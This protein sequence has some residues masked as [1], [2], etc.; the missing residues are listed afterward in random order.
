MIM[1]MGRAL[2]YAQE[3]WDSVFGEPG[4]SESGELLKVEVR[5]RL[6]ADLKGGAARSAFMVWDSDAVDIGLENS[7][8]LTEN[9]CNFSGSTLTSQPN[10]LSH[11]SANTTYTFSLFHRNVSPKRSKK[12][13]LPSD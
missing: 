4:T 3:H 7:G 10:L 6:W 9:F 1:D 12:Y 13:H 5:L 11:I 2:H 8:I